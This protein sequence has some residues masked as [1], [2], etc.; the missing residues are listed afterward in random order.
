MA[1]I[2]RAVAASIKAVS[3]LLGD[4]ELDKRQDHISFDK[5][6][7][8]LVAPINRVLGHIINTRRMTVSTPDDFIKEVTHLLQTKWGPHRF[9]F[10]INEAE[11]LAGKL[12]T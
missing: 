7:E 6:L 9:R 8:M 1:R 4:S 3:L 10:F 2:R 12:A 11:K 5:L